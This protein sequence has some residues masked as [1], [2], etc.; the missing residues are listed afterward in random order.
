MNLL[1]YSSNSRYSNKCIG[2]AETSLELIA[3]KMVKEDADV[4]YATLKP[5][6]GKKHIY[7]K[8]PSFKKKEFGGITVFNGDLLLCPCRK[9]FFPKLQD[10]FI[11]Y[12]VQ[13]FLGKIMESQK[14][15]LAHS[16]EIK[17]TYNVLKARERFHLDVKI[18][19]RVSGLFWAHAIDIKLIT[20]DQT[21]WVFNSVDAVNYLTPQLRDLVLQTAKKYDLQLHPKKEIILDIGI[22]LDLFSYQW[23][24]KTDD[25]FKIVSVSKFSFHQKKPD[26]LIHA[27]SQLKHKNFKMDFFGVGSDLKKCKKLC[28]DLGISDRVTFHGFCSQ[29]NIANLLSLADLFVLPSLYEGLPKALLEAMAVGVPCLVSDVAPINQYIR[30]EVNGFTVKNTPQDWAQKLDFLYTQG[31]GLKNV[32]LK[33]REFVEQNYDAAVN[34]LKYKKEFEGLMSC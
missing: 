3:Q 29:E 27:L 26:L 7:P 22:D 17:D 13:N 19:K 15:N 16:Y 34:I 1:V 20:K 11:N 9:L 10:R 28:H 33:A 5:S 23:K 31:E 25:I 32:S 6:F 21:E 12:Q 14:I 4:S 18:V 24:P 2:G 8:S 30:D